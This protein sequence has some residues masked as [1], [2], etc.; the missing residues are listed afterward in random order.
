MNTYFSNGSRVKIAQI[1]DIWDYNWTSTAVSLVVSSV[2][3]LFEYSLVP[4]I[5]EQVNKQVR[6]CKYFIL[7]HVGDFLLNPAAAPILSSI[8]APLPFFS[9]VSLAHFLTPLPSF[10]RYLSQGSTAELDKPLAWDHRQLDPNEEG[11]FLLFSKK[12]SF[13]DLIVLLLKY[14]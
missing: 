11:F 14:K 5:R 13:Q 2:L 8:T 7:S 4:E 1:F 10:L 9:C 6:C 12:T 3:F